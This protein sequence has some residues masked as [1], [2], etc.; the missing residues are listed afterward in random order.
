MRLDC[1]RTIRKLRRERG[2]TLAQAAHGA[3]TTAAQVMKLE[4]GDR[5]MTLDWLERLAKALDCN[6]LDIIAPARQT[7]IT[8]F[9]TAQWAVQQAVRDPRFGTMPPSLT[10]AVPRGCDPDNIIAI[11]RQTLDRADFFSGAT[12]YFERKTEP[13]QLEIYDGRICLLT[14]ADGAQNVRRIG[15]TNPNGTVTRE[16]H[17]HAPSEAPDLSGKVVSCYPCIAIVDGNQAIERICGND[18]PREAPMC[19]STQMQPRPH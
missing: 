19:S 11:R 6:V 18:I 15:V 2:M 13:V 9:L 1:P 7:P 3:G 12:F 10:V 16:V 17:Y 14:T 4:N 8:G 5:R